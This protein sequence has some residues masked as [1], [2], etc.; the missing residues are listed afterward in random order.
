MPSGNP[1]MTITIEPLADR[2]TNVCEK[3]GKWLP[4]TCDWPRTGAPEGLQ[5]AIKFEPIF[6]GLPCLVDAL[7]QTLKS[8]PYSLLT[9]VK[10]D[11]VGE[12]A[13]EEPRS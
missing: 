5:G 3:R 11:H 12:E 9:Q 10:H 8:S 4:N 7:L 1:L 13:E 2:I 6:H